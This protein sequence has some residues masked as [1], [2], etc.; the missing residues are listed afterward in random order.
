MGKVL[1]NDNTFPFA[2]K[3][4]SIAFNQYSLM[5]LRVS[6]GRGGG[7]PHALFPSLRKA[8]FNNVVSF[9]AFAEK[10][11]G[12]NCAVFW[13]KRGKA[14][15]YFNTLAKDVKILFKDWWFYDL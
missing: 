5:F 14:L 8:L 1:S 9:Y 7:N 11:S 13:R 15:H 2:F 10:N 12:V 6:G 3:W 4:H